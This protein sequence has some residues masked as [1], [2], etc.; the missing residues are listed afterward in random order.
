VFNPTEDS[1][2][3]VGLALIVISVILGLNVPHQSKAQVLAT[4]L[5]LAGAA[6]MTSGLIIWLWMVMP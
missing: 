5:L 4:V 1:V 6:L 2:T 3:A